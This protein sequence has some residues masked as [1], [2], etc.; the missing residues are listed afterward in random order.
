MGID[1][2]P[3]GETLPPRTD[4]SHI[5]DD[6]Y[7]NDDDGEG[8]NINSLQQAWSKANITQVFGDNEAFWEACQEPRRILFR[9]LLQEVVAGTPHG[10]RTLQLPSQVNTNLLR[11][12]IA[13]E[14][15]LEDK[16]TEFDLETRQTVAIMAWQELN[17]RLTQAELLM[18]RQ[19]ESGVN[20]EQV[21]LRNEM[22]AALHVTPLPLDPAE[23]LKPGTFLVAHPL[24][25]LE[26]RKTVICILDHVEGSSESGDCTYG[27]FVNRLATSSRA[28][29]G[30]E[31]REV[32]RKLPIELAESFGDSIVYEGGDVHM[33]W[34]M[35]YATAEPLD[36]VGGNVLPMVTDG[37]SS[38]A[39]NTDRAIYYKGDMV[40]AAIAVM[41]G[42]LNKCMFLE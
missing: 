32:L 3:E 30:L 21:R 9:K 40:N 19:Y 12:V 41:N 38:A 36:K 34:Q 11:E 6:D 15:R 31:V 7:C 1:V 17:M 26:V 37:D 20:A 23:Y 14:F 4:R 16:S 33:S 25:P 29:G 22:Q 28:C 27:L 24:A 8:K 35:V 2:G 5:V 39:L 42:E 18:K 10:F 13:R